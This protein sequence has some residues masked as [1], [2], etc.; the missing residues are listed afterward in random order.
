M[1]FFRAV[2]PYAASFL[3]FIFF[4]LLYQWPHAL[5]VSSIL[6]LLG[7]SAILFFLLGTNLTT[8]LS[9]LQFMITPLTL[10]G[11][12]YAF[13]LFI[14]TTSLYHIFALIPSLILLLYFYFLY[15]YVWRHDHYIP[16]SLEHTASYASIISLFFLTGSLSAAH[17]FL[18]V[19]IIPLTILFGLIVTVLTAH[20]VWMNKFSFQETKYII[21]MTALMLTEFFIAALFLPIPFLTTAAFLAI[22]GYGVWEYMRHMLLK[23]LSPRIISRHAIYGTIL[24]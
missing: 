4:E 2:L 21:T 3:T 13:I 22:L 7:L 12:T 23:T 15:N 11:T 17:I 19:S 9:R 10:I 24:L 16:F 5:F 8:P 20:T 1:L 6:L 18:A 14:P